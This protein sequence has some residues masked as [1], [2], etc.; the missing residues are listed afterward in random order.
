MPFVVAVRN[1][2]EEVVETLIK[3]GADVDGEEDVFG[4]AICT[5]TYKAQKSF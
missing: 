5:A 2:Y 4:N 1:G 3:R